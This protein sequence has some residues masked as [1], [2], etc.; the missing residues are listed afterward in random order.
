MRYRNVTVRVG[1]G[2]VGWPEAEPFD[3]IAITAA[4]EDLPAAVVGQ[5]KPEGRLV[6]PLGPVGGPQYLYRYRHTK[7]GEVARDVVL[8]VMFVPLVKSL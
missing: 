4:A 8:P 5:L 2:R 7:K 6:A 1:D 3:G